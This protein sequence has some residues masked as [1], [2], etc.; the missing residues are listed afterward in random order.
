MPDPVENG[1]FIPTLNGQGAIW[2]YVDQV[3]QAYL[4]FVQQTRGV[5]LEVAAGY[6]HLVIQALEAGAAKVFANELDAGQLAIIRSRVP[7]KY[8][9]ELVCCPGEFPE[10]TTFPDDTFDGIYNAR[11]FHFFTGDRIRASLNA[12]HRWLK[13]GGQ[14]FLVNDAIYR[15][16]FKTLIPIYEKQVASGAEWPGFIEDVRSCIPEYLHPAT[17][18]ATMNFMDP[19]VL[20]RELKRVGFRVLTANFFPYTGPF[21]LGRLDGREIA[22]AIGRKEM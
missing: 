3:T 22:A 11:L 16:I 14:V 1:A 7:A 21:A 15:T 20:S 18:P 13:P 6:G 4:D 2:L 5:L 12:M 8:T 10:Q 17:F 9:S 19:T